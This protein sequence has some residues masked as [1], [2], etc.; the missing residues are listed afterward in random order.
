MVMRVLAL[1]AL[2]VQFALAEN[3]V[4]RRDAAPQPLSIDPSEGWYAFL[5]EQTSNTT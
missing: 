2:L 3:G 4:G 5:H 1:L